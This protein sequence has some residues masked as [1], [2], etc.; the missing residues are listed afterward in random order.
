VAHD[1]DELAAAQEFL[2]KKERGLDQS[3]PVEAAPDIRI[4]VADRNGSRH[5]EP[6]NVPLIGEFEVE[7]SSR[8]G[9]QMDG[10]VLGKI[11][12]FVRTAVPLYVSRARQS[13]HFH[14]SVLP[15]YQTRVLEKPYAYCA[16]HSFSNKVDTSVT[17]AD[18]QID[19]WVHIAKF[20]NTRHDDNSTNARRQVD[21][22]GPVNSA[23]PIAQ[24]TFGFLKLCQDPNAELIV[25]S[26]L[27]GQVDASC[28]TVQEPNSEMSLEALDD[29]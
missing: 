28:G 2:N 4:Y 3:Y 26:A 27:C 11:G 10:E 24:R 14:V 23:G 29:D 25:L 21:P 7:V 6:S 22:E 13:H 20:M 16:V 18:S 19:L 15:C 8:P 12:N 5:A 9:K 1:F 17:E